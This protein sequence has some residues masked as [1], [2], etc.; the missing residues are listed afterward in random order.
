MENNMFDHI[1][2]DR[3]VLEIGTLYRFAVLYMKIVCAVYKMV[4]YC[5]FNLT[6][7]SSTLG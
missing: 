1:I 3:T 2:I 4:V 7:R 6:F 5:F